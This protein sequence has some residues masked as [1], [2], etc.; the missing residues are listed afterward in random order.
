VDQDPDGDGQGLVYNLRF[1][2]QYYDAETDLNYNMARD[3]DPATGRYLESDPI[4]LNGGADTFAYAKDDPVV[5]I[6]PSGLFSLTRESTVPGLMF[7]TYGSA[8]C[9]HWA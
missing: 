7:V 5:G 9:R 1:P 2:G 3:Y 6:D 8:G 4:G